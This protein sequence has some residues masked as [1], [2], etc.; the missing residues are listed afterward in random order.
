MS[1]KVIITIFGASGDLAKRKLYPSLFRLY[2]SGNLSKHFAVIGTAR[3]PWSKEYFE[4]VVVESITDLADSPE[5]AQEFASHFY[6]QSHDVQDTEHYIELRKLQNSLDEQYQAEHNKLF[7]LS[8]APQFFGTIAKHLKSEQ[9][10][11]GKGF[12]RLIVEKPFGTDLASAS[13]LNDDLLATF[14]EEQIF[15]IDHYLGKEMIQSIFA[16]RFANLLFENVWNR[17]YIDNVQIT[18]AEK[19]GVEERGGYYDHSGALRDMVQNHT[20]QLLSLLAM[21]KPKTFTKDDIRA[22]KIKV[23]KH[24]HKPTDND[25]KK[26][27]IRGQY[28][29]GKVDGKKYISYRSEPNVDPESTTET[30]ASGA[31]FVDSERF[32]G[33]PFFFRTGK[34][35]T[36]KGTHVNIVFKQVESIFGSSLQPNVLTIYI[37]PTEG[38]SLSMNGKEVGEQFNLAPLTLDYRTDATASGASPEPYEKLIYD[39]LNNDSTNFSHWDEVRSSWELIDRIETLWANNEVPLHHYKSG[40]MGPEASFELLNQFEADWNWR[41]DEA[42]RKEGRLG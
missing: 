39:V 5:Q 4:S 16:I 2:K 12:E 25:L 6:Y 40:T 21:D 26:L 24:L 9:I 41:P 29:S 13:K 34:R 33:V 8:M 22:E 31:F 15:R 18:F 11:D 37:Q 23:F 30:F 1:S 7:F 19:L 3:R 42:Y 14:D 10:V 38:F 35:L 36:A 20:L 28:T 17:D 32:R 27:F